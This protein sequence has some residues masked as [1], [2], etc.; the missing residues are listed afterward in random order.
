MIGISVF[1][2]LDY[3]IEENIEYIDKA[4]KRGIKYVFTSVHIPNLDRKRVTSE[5]KVLL[6][7]TEKRNMKLMVDISKDFYFEFDWDMYSVHALRL[8]FGFD[9][10]E[11]VELSKKYN[12]QLN[13]STI[14]KEW[15]ERLVSLGLDTKRVTVCH[16]YYPRNDTGISLELLRER[17]NF[18]KVT[19]CFYHLF[20]Q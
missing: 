13:A 20:L 3:T 17:N 14:S 7:E 4:Y 15:M 12:I 8:D 11:I 1:S 9:D 18:F 2:G 6:E 10:E 19:K 5:F 16:N